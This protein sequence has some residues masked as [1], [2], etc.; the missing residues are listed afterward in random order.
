MKAYRLGVI[1]FGRRMS[2]VMKSLLDLSPDS[3]VIAVLDKNE[4]YAR[5]NMKNAGV[6]PD[7]VRFFTDETA[8]FNERQPDGILIGTNCVDHAQYATEVLRRNIPLF[9]EK[10]V[11]IT[12]RDLDLL[13]GYAVKNPPVTV[14]F[15]LRVT[16]LFARAME[17]VKSG[18]LGKISQVQAVNNVYYGRGY[19]KKWYRNDAL[20]GGLFLQKA[21]HDV[22]CIF[23]LLGGQLPYRVIAVSRKNIFKG[24][25][26]AGLHCADCAERESCPESDWNLEKFDGEPK[27]PD[28]CVFATDTGN[29][30]SGS[31]ILLFPSGIHAVYTQNFVV[32]KAAGRREIR[33]IGYDGTLEIS[34]GENELRLFNHHTGAVEKCGF[35]SAARGHHGG[36]RMLMR[37]FLSLLAGE[38]TPAGGLFDGVVSA[39]VCLAARES[40]DKDG[41]PVEPNF[42]K[43]T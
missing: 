28:T 23:T 33:V 20:T 34:F 27:Q 2:D 36:D 5:E 40:A 22:D 3:R 26:P 4:S 31:M 9:L 1:G 11:G 25:H 10:P 38:S 18:V 6:D 35:D 14:S 21:T 7:A 24:N 8:F 19:Y 43:N 37:D 30:D 41:M 32:R 39:A 29:E 42:P 15:P 13:S 16:P 12:H 17:I